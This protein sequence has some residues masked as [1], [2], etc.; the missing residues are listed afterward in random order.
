MARAPSRAQS[1][2]TADLIQHASITGE[3]AKNLWGRTD[4]Q[5]Y[6]SG[7]AKASNWFVDYKGGLV[8]RAGFEFGDVIEWA[9]GEN[10]KFTEFEYSPDTANR[11]VL[12]WTD[13]KVRFAQDNAYVLESAV[14]VDSVA[15]GAGDKI[16]ITATGHGFSDGDWVKLS[17]FTDATLT[18]LN[19]RTVEVANKATNTFDINDV[20]TG[21]LITKASISTDTGSVSRIY[22]VAS[23]YS[24]DDLARL[25]AVQARDYV[26]LTHPDYP[27]KNL[28][29]NSAASWTLSNEAIGETPT[30]PTGLAT[31]SISTGASKVHVYMVTAID[32]NGE[33]SLPAVLVTNAGPDLNTDGEWASIDWTA[34]SGAVAYRIYRSVQADDGDHTWSDLTVGYIGEST[35]PAFTDPGITPDFS[36]QPPVA[37]NPFADGRIEYVTVGAGGTGASYNDT[38]TW[39][40][41]GSGA[42]GFLVVKAAGSGT[43]KGVKV[44][45]GG[46]GYTGTTVSDSTASGETLT[47]VLSDASGN[48]P[49]CAAIFQQRMLYGATDN[50][51]LRLFGS[52][53]GLFSNFN[54]SLLATD[55]DSYEFDLD[56]MKVAPVRYIIPG[57]RGVIV[58]TEIG[59]WFLYGRS[60]L[61]LTADNVQA[62]PQNA[63]G[64]AYVRPIYLD[65]EVLYASA[66]GQTLQLLRYDN[67][68][69]QYTGQDVSL[70]S[71]H[72][73]SYDNAIKALTYAKIPYKTVYAVQANGRLLSTTIDVQNGV[74]ACTPNWT[75]GFFREALAVLEDNESRLYVAAERTVQSTKCLFFERQVSRK[76]AT[77][78]EAFCVDAG[79]QLS[80]TSPAGRL[81]PSSSTGSV[82]FTTVGGTPFVSGDVG[83]VIRCGSGKA[84]IS[85]YTSSSEVS[86]T[87]NRDLD[88]TMPED[89][90]SPMEFVSGDWTMDAPATS[91]SGLWHLIG[92]TID[93]LADG[94]V[95]SKTV[96]S[97]GGFSLTTA[98]SRVA[99]G[100]GY[101]CTA[102]TL[103][104]TATDVVMEGRRKDIVGVAIRI[105]EAYGLK[106]GKST[107]KL[108]EIADRAQRLWSI[109]DKLRDEM[110]YELVV[111]DFSRDS[112]IFF[113]QDSPRP[114]TILS[115]IRDIDLGDDKS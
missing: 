65:S 63:V 85:T 64:A 87:W 31:D 6:D 39:P 89:S 23:P 105:H 95:L 17:G 67:Y 41:G 96:D 59:V 99:A 71:N 113:V 52:R 74:Y 8:S 80:K 37:Y 66:A 115:F 107:S 10:V 36:I 4:F 110:I 16:T 106:Y 5:K 27:V 48:N 78:E 44:L 58:F 33:E 94:S 1:G 97:Y 18:F 21:S 30:K 26:R 62:N 86:G 40:A 55:A 13:S 83:S 70:L 114:T 84:T 92:E 19:N 102:Q 91:I 50:Y 100:M 53:P 24:S 109:E 103:P 38:I 77:L 20:I 111:G 2:G 73:F 93:V 76:F 90:A 81:V 15:N 35:G 3:L 14:T 47:A 34:V 98:A 54:K 79:L 75:K 46:A 49:A 57:S 9:E 11:Y 28:V 22:T 12:I 32:I 7:W 25:Q 68:T 112:Q 51:P 72:L 43:I 29:R 61:A 88:E 56:S 60:D 108:Y 82:T 42:Y 104:A 69:H 101:T 45:D